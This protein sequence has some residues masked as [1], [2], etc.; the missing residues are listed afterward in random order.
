MIRIVVLLL[1]S[2]TLIGCATPTLVNA[3][4]TTY[5]TEDYA[6]SGTIAVLSA[7]PVQ[8]DSLQ[9]E[10]FR[11]KI[12][13]RFQEVGH[14]TTRVVADS[15]Y[16]ALV[17]Y[18]VGEGR[19]KLVSLPEYGQTGT[20]TTG[21]VVGSTAGGTG[22]FA[23]S[24]ASTPVYGV[25]GS[26]VHSTVQYDRAMVMRI[27]TTDS[28]SAESPQ[29]VYEGVLKSTGSCSSIDEV[30]DELLGAFFSDWPGK[31]GQTRAKRI[32]AMVNC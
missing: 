25:T 27:F 2:T 14:E 20:M 31:N 21:S 5:L 29:M 17:A 3:N 9:F 16:I 22:T 15:D 19:Q 13:E 11:T 1:L 26:S 12:E 23:G 10:H 28:V 6:T 30:F 18:G 7:P 8:E 32:L 4:V 24:A